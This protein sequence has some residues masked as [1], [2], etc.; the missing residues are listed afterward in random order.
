MQRKIS[1]LG[2]KNNIPEVIGIIISLAGL[3]VMAGWFFNIGLLKSILPVWVTMKFSTALSFFL[4]GIELYLI[5]RFQKQ[6]RDF[7]LVFLPIISMAIF[8]L[9]S[10]LI[11]STV[12]GISVGVED[13]FVKESTQALGSV[14]PGRPSVATMINFILIASAGILISFSFNNLIKLIK[15]LGVAVCLVGL[16]AL[17]GYISNHPWLYFSITGRSS[18][19]AVHTAILFVLWGYGLILTKNN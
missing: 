1:P 18:G 14:V 8:L 6:E 2:E 12:I 15:I 5:A 16:S 13:F 11:A 10:S 9:M 17:F 3:L 19:M 4:C 7:A